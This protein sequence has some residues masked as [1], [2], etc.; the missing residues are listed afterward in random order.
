MRAVTSSP[1]PAAAA[2][3]AARL[4]EADLDAYSLVVANV[5]VDV[6]ANLGIRYTCS[7]RCRTTK[8]THHQSA[9]VRAPFTNRN[10]PFE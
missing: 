5:V 8:H 3:A 9:A 6:A 4:K 1:E 10:T 7:A 2:A